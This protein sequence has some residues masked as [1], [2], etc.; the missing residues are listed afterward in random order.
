MLEIAKKNFCEHIVILS[1]A[2]SII[3]GGGF[4]RKETLP[5]KKAAQ[6]AIFHVQRE[7]ERAAIE[8]GKAAIALCDR[9]TLDG[10]AYWPEDQEEFFREL[11]INREKELTRYDA[12]IHLRTPGQHQGYNLSN[13]I[14]IESAEQAAKIDALIEKAW[15]GHPHREFIESGSD[16]IVKAQ[17]AM[18]VIR[19]ALPPCCRE[20][21]IKEFNES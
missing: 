15:D 17:K 4:T 10:L 20:H 3:Y 13:P 5:S 6:R 18:E 1:E 9:G 21:K 14:R 2:A 7:M 11:G 16:F 12:V 19:K 8:E